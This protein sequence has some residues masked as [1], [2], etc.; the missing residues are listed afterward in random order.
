MKGGILEFEMTDQ[1][2]KTAFDEAPVSAIEGRSVTVPRIEGDKMFTK[3]SWIFMRA[4]Y[5]RGQDLLHSR[6]H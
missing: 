3:D 2:V 6:R 5:A 4:A 1:P